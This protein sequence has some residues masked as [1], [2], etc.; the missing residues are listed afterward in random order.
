VI[1]PVVIPE[2]KKEKSAP[3]EVSEEPEEP[4]VEPEEEDQS[5]YGKS[6]VTYVY[7]KFL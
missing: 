6:K 1:V 7:V 3:E 4:E 5:F 2:D